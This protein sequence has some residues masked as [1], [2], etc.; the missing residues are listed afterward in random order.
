MAK[1]KRIK[2]KPLGT[3]WRI[4][5]ELWA[6][7]EPILCD[8]WPRKKEGRPPANWRTVL[9]GIIFRMRSGCQW[10]QLPKEFGPKSTVHD[11]FQ[12]WNT[13]GVMENIWATLVEN[14]QELGAVHWKWQ[15]A[16]GA[17]G[18][19]RFGGTAS[20]PTQQIE[21]RTVPSAA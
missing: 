15:S 19:A 1:R 9:E 6:I 13:N 2:P 12:R 4:P 7:I 17:M 8:F 18:K 3:I 10:D 11:W 20:D 14:C 16:D 5:D 21:Q